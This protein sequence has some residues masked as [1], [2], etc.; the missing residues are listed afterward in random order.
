MVHDIAPD[1]HCYKWAIGDKA[2]VDS[3]FA[4]A[5]HVTKLDLISNRLIP[6]AMEPRV[7]IGS[8]N[9][10]MDE[11]VVRGQPEPACRAPADDGLC[12]GPARARC[13]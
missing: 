12:H 5:A 7:A 8:Y 2:A 9:R 1:N 13:A 6:N 4:T 10:A 11:Y 3:V